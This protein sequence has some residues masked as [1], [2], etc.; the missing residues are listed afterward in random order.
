MSNV[1]DRRLRAVARARLSGLSS[2]TSLSV[3][4]GYTSLNQFERVTI[5]SRT[6]AIY[7]TEDGTTP[8]STAGKDG[9]VGDVITIEDPANLK[10][11][12]ATA[13]ATVEVT[14]YAREGTL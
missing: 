12:E 9:A 1:N 13:S 2:A 7:Y 8:T 6:Q 3:P 14:F 4:T 10:I 5:Q 11:L